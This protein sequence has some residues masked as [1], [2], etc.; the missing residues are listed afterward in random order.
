MVASKVDTGG[1]DQG[2]ALQ[3][4]HTR[5]ADYEMPDEKTFKLVSNDLGFGDIGMEP[6]YRSITMTNG[7]P[8]AGIRQN[9]AM[10]PYD[11]WWAAIKEDWERAKGGD[12]HPDDWQIQTRYL[13]PMLGGKGYSSNQEESSYE[14]Y[15]EKYYREPDNVVVH[16]AWTLDAINGTKNVELTP[17]PEYYDADKVNFDKIKIVR[18]QSDRANR[19]AI[20]ANSQDYYRGNVPSHIAQSVPDDIE[21]RMVA[22]NGGL[23]FAVNHRGDLLGKRQVRQAIVHAIDASRLARSVH[24]EKYSVI[25]TPGG[26]AWGGESELG[27]DWIENNLQ[28]FGERDL[29]TAASLMQSAGYTREGGKWTDSDGNPVT[30][31]IPSAKATPTL[32]PTLAGQLSSFGIDATLQTYSGTIFG[33]KK[34]AGEFNI[35]STNR[36]LGFNQRAI[37]RLYLYFMVLEPW[38]RKLFRVFPKE[39]VDAVNYADIGI[40]SPKEGQSQLENVSPCTIEAP[41]IGEPDGELQTYH[42]PKLSLIAMGS[43]D[44]DIAQEAYRKLAWVY[45]Y[46][47]PIIPIANARTQH[48]LDS[49]HWHWPGADSNTWQVAGNI[50]EHLLSYG[51]F[52]QA[53]PNNTEEGASV[54]E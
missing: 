15:W 4:L 37:G 54:E 8:W 18:R 51:R 46:D 53:N 39:Q 1:G 38:A 21:Q 9:V 5:V 27:Q 26:H 50:P 24:Q 19:A 48:F 33:E 34:N 44:P 16:G 36:G 7:G 30:M 2:Y 31:E 52:L 17:N 32:A 42:P 47:M 13:E 29:E 45:N 49:G 23:G 22:A 43:N 6:V 12:W 3:G 11:D 28:N 10:A 20:N 41:P 14:Q 40:I 35:W 25:E